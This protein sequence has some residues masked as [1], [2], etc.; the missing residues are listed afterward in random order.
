MQKLLAK[1]LLSL[2][3]FTIIIVCVITLAN[4]H[5][6]VQDIKQR[7]DE[8]RALIENHILSDMQMV[9]NAHFYFNRTYFEQMKNELLFLQNYYES[10]PDIYSWDVQEINDRTG[11]QLYIID[12]QNK[13]VVST[14][15]PSVGLDLSEC[16]ARF[17][18]FLDKRR[19]WDEFY[20]DGIE[21]AEVTK[22]LWKFS[23]LPTKDKQYIL[24]LGGEL[25]GSPIFK[26]FNYFDTADSLIV[27]Y[28]DLHSIEII[29]EEGFFLQTRDDIKTIDEL[30]T[31]LKEVYQKVTETDQPAEVIINLKNGK[32][33]TH[34]FIPYHV[35]NEQG[36]STKRIIYVQYSN[37]TEL[38]LLYK[39]TQQFWMLLGVGIVT[40]GILLVIILKILTETIRLATFDQLTGVYNRSSYLK[41]IERLIQKKN[42]KHIGLLLIDLDNFKQVN[43]QYG[44]LEGDEVLKQMADI[45]RN[46]IGKK[47]SVVRFGGDEFAIVL[48]DA[49]DQELHNI[50]NDVLTSVRKKQQEHSIWKLLSVSIG[51]T[52]Q[53]NPQET[54]VN[55]FMRGDKALYQSKNMGK[56]QYSFISNK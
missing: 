36:D 11:M 4:R 53:E 21:N 12:S 33:D 43:D 9:D 38:Q 24:E 10:N 16:C 20:T 44:H 14:N 48:E 6:L 17:A 26:T 47:G 30:S 40:A 13:I 8:S 37:C 55:I 34:R 19:Q 41:Y 1:L 51:G 23:F 50:A 27:E 49:N 22:D 28:E 5:L 42:M 39:N 25:Q 35:V 32:M 46:A 45:L 15:E 7:Q 29:S 18:A 3:I 56:D 54:E 2:L 52:I 31:E